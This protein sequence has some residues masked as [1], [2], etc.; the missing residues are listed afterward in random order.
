MERIHS[1]E[2]QMDGSRTMGWLKLSQT[3]GCLE[4]WNY[5]DTFWNVREMLK[6]SIGAERWTLEHLQALARLIH[7]GVLDLHPTG[8]S[9][10]SGLHTAFLVT[11][12]LSINE[13]L[14]AERSRG[15]THPQDLTGAGGSLPLWEHTMKFYWNILTVTGF[16][17]NV[18]GQPTR[19]RELPA[20]H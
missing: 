3:E 10:G 19:Y 11:A 20:G 2:L 13:K 18:P 16:M 6:Q 9:T 15:F 14:Q 5:S 4:D 1:F 12:W 7:F 8:F 17:A